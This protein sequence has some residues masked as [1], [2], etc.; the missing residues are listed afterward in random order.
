M[1]EPLTPAQM[2][3]FV[4]NGARLSHQ[5]G[6]SLLAEVERLQAQLA[7]RPTERELADLIER[8]YR[9]KIGIEMQQAEHWAD[10]NFP[11]AV[12]HRVIAADNNYQIVAMCER[13]RTFNENPFDAMR[14]ELERPPIK[15]LGTYPPS[16]RLHA[17]RH[18]SYVVEQLKTASREAGG[19][20]HE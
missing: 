9:R 8:Y 6:L 4:D 13:F 15:P 17:Y 5:D 2:R 20:D 1:S 14:R 16:E 3:T 10:R 12:H 18:P 7:K 11:L 19:R